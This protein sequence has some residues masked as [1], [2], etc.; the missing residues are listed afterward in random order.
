MADASPS[1]VAWI[2]TAT[3]PPD[4]ELA[5]GVTFD[6][7]PTDDVWFNA[8][9]KSDD[10]SNENMFELASFTDHSVQD[11]INTSHYSY[12]DALPNTDTSCA[13]FLSSCTSRPL[14]GLTWVLFLTPL[15]F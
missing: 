2:T 9:S 7:D 10:E 6:P 15:Y 12:M 5:T 3:D 8:R 13:T 11:N 1:D 14:N 4:F